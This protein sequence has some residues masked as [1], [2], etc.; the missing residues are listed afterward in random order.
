LS[1]ESGEY[2]C[3]DGLRGWLDWRKHRGEEKEKEREREGGGGERERERERATNSI[4]FKDGVAGRIHMRHG[5]GSNRKKCL[6]NA[7][8][9]G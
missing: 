2:S 3:I 7:R 4:M 8:G 5:I 9:H 1:S 6:G